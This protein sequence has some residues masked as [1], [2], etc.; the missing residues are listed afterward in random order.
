MKRAILSTALIGLTGLS[1]A[2]GVGGTSASSDDGSDT[3]TA[4]EKASPTAS[5]PLTVPVGKTMKVK[6]M[7]AEAKVT[8]TKAKSYDQDQ[9]PDFPQSPKNGAFE[10]IMVKA[11]SVKGQFPVNPFYFKFVAAG[12]RS[13]EMTVATFDPTLDAIDLN[14]GQSTSGNVA[15]DVP[16]SATK[17]SK[18]EI[19]DAGGQPY[20]YWKL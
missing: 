2:C 13:Y 1:V 7:D 16:K 8:L 19:S 9:T 17:G 18:I 11:V 10:V 3:S 14:A 12:G 5:G 20:G 6:T 15:F 4:S